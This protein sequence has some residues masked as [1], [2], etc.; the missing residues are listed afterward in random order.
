[1]QRL[2]V[3]D[4]FRE[5]GLLKQAAEHSGRRYEYRP[6]QQAMAEIA[7]HCLQGKDHLVIEAPTGTGKSFAYL[8]PAILR[9]LE[10]GRPLL[11]S[12]DTISLQEQLINQDIPAIQKILDIEFKA[13]LAKGRGNYLCKRRLN[14]AANRNMDYLPSDE[15]VPEI[16]KIYLWSKGAEFGSRSEVDFPVNYEA[17][18]A[19]NSEQGNC[20][21]QACPH[22]KGC[23]FQRARRQLRS[24]NIIV[25]NHALLF[26]D[27]AIKTELNDDNAGILPR[28][29]GLILDEA[30]T[31]EHSAAMNLGIRIHAGG[32]FRLLNRIYHPKR[33]R[34]LMQRADAG[35][36]RFITMFHR[37]C[38]HYFDSLDEWFVDRDLPMRYMEPGKFPNYLGDGLTELESH[39]YREAAAE[40]NEER[41]VELNS[42]RD[43]CERLR[44]G[45]DFFVTMPDN[46]FVYWF[47]DTGSTQ[48]RI[49]LN[50]VPIDIAPLLKELL[51]DRP[52]PIIMT[53]ATLAVEGS[54]DYYC[55]RIGVSRPMHQILDTPFDYRT[56][57]R[58]LIP[59]NMPHPND[60]E[61]FSVACRQ[62]LQQIISMTE[63]KAFVL[64]TS[65][66]MLNE[67]AEL[68]RPWFDQRGWRL[69]KQGEG[70]S[71]MRLVDEFK[72]DINSVLFGTDSFWT[73]IDVPGEALSNVIIIKLP[74]AVPDH[75]V[76]EAKL[77]AITERGGNPF[78]ELSVPEAVLKLRQGVGRLIRSQ[79]DTGYI[80]ILDSRIIT[81]RYGATFLK[82][83]PPAPVEYI[84]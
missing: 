46:N 36:K 74:F 70:L 14:S 37:Q 11:I 21:N 73:G 65:Y 25:S 72:Q 27:L 75:P 13:V 42:A 19:V 78:L 17:W 2:S 81:K 30:H 12:T 49:S 26:S 57:A 61:A 66:R 40:E 28:Y 53:S 67:F 6:Q 58:V 76:M 84:D 80:S 18:S 1:M 23:F 55:K 50:A 68:L 5:N 38:R 62:K 9:A 69:L 56:Q 10:I 8:I 54:L 31:V 3:S 16:D 39:L 22:Y 29:S 59:R 52:I 64:F 82:S 79:T 77:E 48:N 7:A 35:F 41:L 83:L 71:N 44:L 24:A 34:G 33:K 51:F 32:V 15:L 20:L 60:S 4:I 47:E 45:L 43:R 63:G